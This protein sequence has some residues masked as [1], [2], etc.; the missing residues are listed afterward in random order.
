M[1]RF[2]LDSRAGNTQ[3]E[4]SIFFNARINE[5]LNRALFLKEEECIAFWWKIGFAFCFMRPIY[6]QR[7]KSSETGSDLIFINIWRKPT[8]KN[9]SRE[10]FYSFSILMS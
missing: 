8:N 1:N 4:F 10:A 5:C 6:Y 3:V 7:S 2:V 9:F